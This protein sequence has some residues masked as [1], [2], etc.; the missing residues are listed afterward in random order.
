MGF[1]YN[2]HMEDETMAN[3]R[4]RPSALRR[5]G[6]TLTVIVA[7]VLIM[8]LGLFLLPIFENADA[9]PVAGSENWMA[10][11]PDGAGLNELILP[12][13]HDSATKYVQLAYF[14]KCQSL[15]IGDQL[16]A[17]FRYLDIRLG[18]DG[19]TDGFKLMHGFTNC[20]T[21]VFGG[22]LKL[23]AVLAEC[24][25][26]LDEHPTETVLFAV[27]YE[28]GDWDTAAVQNRLTGY[29]AQNPD[30]WLLT[31]TLP[32]LGEARG[33]L[34]LLRRWEDAANLGAQAGVPFLWPDQK[35]H[36]DPALNTAMTDEG[37][38]RLWVQ[39]RF[40]YSAEDK[41]AAFTA[42][43]DAPAG[44]GDAVLSFL[45]TKGTAAYG[46]PYQFAEKLNR[47]LLALDASALRGWIAVDY[48]S[49]A[50][51]A[52]IYGANF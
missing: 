51:A 34:V 39:D 22:A 13:T 52:A 44:E 38:Y 31:D 45:S 16:R 28:H 47:K 48:A 3:E 41:W 19:K 10:A 27:K 49:P 35:G 18:T 50:L 12:G 20:K 21:G 37:T 2:R 1:P 14:S 24:Y 43:L 42:G 5:M 33:R 32:T 11:L 36:D 4:K 7:T 6:L 30:R 25:A 15:G 46:H 40:E 9:T 17:G 26:F 8:A 23:D 29:L